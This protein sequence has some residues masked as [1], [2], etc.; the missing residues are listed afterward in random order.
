[1]DQKFKWF[2][3]SMYGDITLEKVT[4]KATRLILVGLSPTEKEV[5]KALFQRATKPGALQSVWATEEAV[6]S[7]DL[8]SFRE[9]SLQLNAPISRV[10]DFLQKKLKPHRKQ[11]SAVRFTS[12][13]MEEVS[14]ATL[15][16]IDSP[17]S[18]EESASRAEA[19][20]PIPEPPPKPA[21][22]ERPERA[23][24]VA[25][26]VLGCPAPDFDD[27]QQRANAVL[28]AF[29]TEEQVEDYEERGQFVA[30]G[31]ETG[32]RYLLTSRTSRHALGHTSFRSL[33][34]V[35]EERAFCVHDWEVPSGEEL[36]GLLVHLSIPGLESYARGIPD[37][38]GV[39]HG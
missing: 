13:R 14:E 9:Q 34:D 8:G 7:V 4:D 27:A 10:Q 24:T 15:K 18:H 3:P 11:V 12:G 2:L 23:V 36:L 26:P 1:M 19:I 16:I 37:V 32:H 38:A 28:R 35:D 31:V 30:L 17:A 21:K 6:R 39:L 33:Y 29:L 20:T 25:Q 5:V 22:V